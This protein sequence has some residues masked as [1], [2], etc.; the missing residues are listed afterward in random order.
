MDYL[1]AS[2]KDR[3]LL[4]E[5]SA[6]RAKSLMGEG[7]PLEEAALAVD[8]LS[9]EAMLR[10]LAETF[11]LPFIDA[12]RLEKNPP[13]K[14]FLAKFPVRLLV[15]HRLLPLENRDG[16]TLVATSRISDITALDELRLASGNDVAPALATSSEIDRCA[17]EVAWRR[18]RHAAIAQCRK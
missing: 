1:I 5:Q 10:F 7:T 4:D 13:A 15:R 6:Q 16:I 12:D 17:E 2:M 9:E 14:E 3:G 8:G 11:E 18:R